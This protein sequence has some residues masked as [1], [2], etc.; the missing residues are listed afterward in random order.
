MGSTLFLLKSYAVFSGSTHMTEVLRRIPA[1]I[2]KP[3][4]PFGKGNI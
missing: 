2:V 3:L 1:A 4:E